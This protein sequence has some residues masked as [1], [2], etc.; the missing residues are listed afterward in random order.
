MDPSPREFDQQSLLEKHLRVALYHAKFALTR[1]EEGL[2]KAVKAKDY[3]RAG[4][5][6]DAL[7]ELR[8]QVKHYLGLLDLYEKELGGDRGDG[9]TELTTEDLDDL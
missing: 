9:E 3:T 7:Y 6:Q 1:A 2:P 5:Y 8:G 4:S